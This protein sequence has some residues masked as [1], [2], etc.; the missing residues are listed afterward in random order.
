MDGTPLSADDLVVFARVADAGSF[1]R[2]AE[3]AGVPKSTLSRRVSQLEAQLGE[4]LLIRTTRRLML[5]EFGVALLEHAR[6]VIEET[7][8]AA[9]LAQH[10]QALPRGRLRVSVPHDFAAW[11]LPEV[12]AHFTRDH[13]GVSVDLDLSPRRVDLI[14]EGFDLV[15]RMGDL[16]DDATLVARSLCR[17]ER[18]LYANAAYL[19]RRGSPQHPDA[20]RDHHA[21]HLRNQTGEPA[22]WHLQRGDETWQGVPPGSIAA[23]SVGMLLRLAEAGA[24]IAPLALAYLSTEAPAAR[25]VRVLPGWCLPPVTAWAV[26]PGR[27]LLPAKTRV[28]MDAVAAALQARQS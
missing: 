27:R 13:P 3:R 17:M 2:A 1:S 25:L 23:N 10:R 19:E 7:D 18:G 20:L 14:G 16:P 24:G 4:R 8:G 6:R 15:I 9:A 11:L 12:L 21:L 26:T 5:T 28:F 22:P